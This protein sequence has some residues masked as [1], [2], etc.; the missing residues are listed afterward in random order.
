MLGERVEGACA[1]AGFDDA[2][3][4]QEQEVAGL[5]G[6]GFD[7]VAGVREFAEAQWW[8]GLADLEWCD[9]VIA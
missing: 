3:G 1:I 7:A 9:L 4:V 6:E 8:F 2:V 5:E